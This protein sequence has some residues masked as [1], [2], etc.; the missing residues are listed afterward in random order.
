[1]RYIT[2]AD[3]GESIILLSDLEKILELDCEICSFID[4]GILPMYTS[5]PVYGW[6]RRDLIMRLYDAKD[7]RRRLLKLSDAHE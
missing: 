5:I 1:M 2:S 4:A 6:R 3:N 7:A